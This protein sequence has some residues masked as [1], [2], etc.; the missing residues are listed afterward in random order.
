MLSANAKN[1]FAFIALNLTSLSRQKIQGRIKAFTLEIQQLGG[2]ILVRISVFLVLAQTQG[3][4]Q[5]RLK[6]HSPSAIVS[7]SNSSSDS[8]YAGG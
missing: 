3:S 8:P 4:V 2:E 1:T 6:V 5:Y 7:V